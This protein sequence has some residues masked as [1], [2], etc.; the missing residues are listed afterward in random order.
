MLRELR[1]RILLIDDDL[2]MNEALSGLFEGLIAETSE[3][4][5]KPTVET[6]DVNV[7]Q[8]TEQP[9]RWE[10]G[11]ETVARMRQ[12]RGVSP[13]HLTI[14]DYGYVDKEIKKAIKWE[15]KQC[16]TEGEYLLPEDI[17]GRIL[18]VP[19][20]KR[21]DERNVGGD[22]S[23]FETTGR[24]I[25]RSFVSKEFRKALPNFAG[26]LLNTK[27]AF[28]KAAECLGINTTEELFGGDRFYHV[29]EQ[30]GRDFYRELCHAYESRVV[31][32]EMYKYLAS[33]ARPVRLTGY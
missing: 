8:S 10:I 23:V 33:L 3:Y 18:S 27:T 15:A 5:L 17:E 2:K 31:E 30:G 6:L 20:L 25:L 29:Y 21:A 11:E 4:I 7:V 26:R 16:E 1:F 9:S 19:H 24:V 12:L 32:R 22:S 28:P 13:F 14:I